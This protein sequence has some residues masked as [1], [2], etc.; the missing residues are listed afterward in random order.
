LV[1]ASVV[2]SKT[3]RFST[4]ITLSFL[5]TGFAGQEIGMRVGRGVGKTISGDL[6]RYAES[7]GIHMSDPNAAEELGGKIGESFGNYLGKVL[8]STTVNGVSLGALLGHV[9]RIKHI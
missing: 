7:R 4:N 6:E 8:D 5:K 3:I 1:L 2:I 9:S